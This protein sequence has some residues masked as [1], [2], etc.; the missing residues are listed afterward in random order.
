M[1]RAARSAAGRRC[2]AGWRLTAAASSTSAT[3]ETIRYAA[4]PGESQKPTRATTI[5][6]RAALEGLW[7]IDDVPSWLPTRNHLRR[8]AERIGPD[9]ADAD[10]VTTGPEAYRRRD[11]IAV[12][13]A[14][15]L[16]A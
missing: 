13:P 11:G 16:T 6:Y 1:N 15:L 5:A 3:F 2:A 9:L 8:L 4:S 14:A 7:V 10:V 12:I